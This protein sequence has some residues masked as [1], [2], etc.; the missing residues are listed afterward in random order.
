MSL[1][2][3]RRA[4]SLR[5]QLPRA[6][7]G[8][9]TCS[10]T[11]F[12]VPSKTYSPRQNKHSRLITNLTH[13]DHFKRSNNKAPVFDVITRTGVVSATRYVPESISKPD[14][15]VSGI[16]VGVPKEMEA[17]SLQQIDRMR[18][19]CRLAKMILNRVSKCV[20]AGVTTDELDKVAHSF[21]IEHNAYPSPL[22]YR[23]FPKSICTSVNNV[24]CHG[25][26]DDRPLQNGDVISVDV[27]VS[28]QSCRLLMNC[29][30]LLRISMH[31]ISMC[32]CVGKVWRW[33]MTGTRGLNMAFP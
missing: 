33:A 17:K 25:I 29:F 20:Q 24:A 5:T 2:L 3:I 28:P 1:S 12:V 6:T 8:L 4:S 11:Q 9:F 19:S 18:D 22:N 10:T 26:P 16:V 23:W 15:A 32:K 7:N 21:C 14:Y 13:S 30:A 31:C 27:S